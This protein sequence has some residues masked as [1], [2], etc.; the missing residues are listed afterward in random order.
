MRLMI[1]LLLWP[2]LLVALTAEECSTAQGAHE[3]LLESSFEVERTFR[4]TVNDDLKKR[5]VSLLS[6]SAG[7]LETEVLE[8]EVHSKILVFDTEDEDFVLELPFACERLVEPAPGR[9]ELTSE[10]GLEVAEFELDVEAGALRPVAWRLDTTARFLFKKLVMAGRV[11]YSGFE[12][13]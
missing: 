7:E 1:G 6:Y 5:E 4:M 3:K 10:D 2:G 13:K 12:W 9:Y 8:D 11:E